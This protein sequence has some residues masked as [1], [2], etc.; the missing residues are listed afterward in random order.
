MAQVYLSRIRLQFRRYQGWTSSH[1]GGPCLGQCL[2]DVVD[3]EVLRCK[4]GKM[5][6][7]W[8]WGDSVGAMMRGTMKLG[9]AAGVAALMVSCTDVRFE[10]ASQKRIARIENLLERVE[11]KEAQAPDRLADTQR[12]A[13][14]A[15]DRHRGWLQK[16][17][18]FVDGVLQREVNR[19]PGRWARTVAFT[20]DYLDGDLPRAN[21]T[22][23]RLLY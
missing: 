4:I 23:P 6:R 11:K 19:W 21:A 18:A 2:A 17:L 10:R 12:V 20:G 22:I 1:D 5:L 7:L 9:L 8:R 14:N 15:I 16:D 13:T 3:L